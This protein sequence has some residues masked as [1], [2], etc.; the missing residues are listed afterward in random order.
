M[1]SATNTGRAGEH[2]V[3]HL[4]ILRGCHVS[5]VDSEGIDLWVRTP[6]GD[7]AT[8]EVKSAYPRASESGQNRPIRYAYTLHNKVHAEYIAFVALDLGLFLLRRS[9]AKAAKQCAI[10]RRHFTPEAMEE[11][12]NAHLLLKPPA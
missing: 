3:A 8:I 1:V 10:P 9:P 12:V 7:T 4:L 11:T 2:L 6:T 5:I